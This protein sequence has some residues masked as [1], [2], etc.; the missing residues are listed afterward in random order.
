MSWLNQPLGWMLVHRF[1]MPLVWHGEASSPF[2]VTTLFSKKTYI[3]FLFVLFYFFH[4]LL[5]SCF[6]EPNWGKR[7]AFL[8]P[9]VNICF[10]PL[11]SCPKQQLCA[12]CCDPVCRYRF[13][14]SLCCNSHLLYH[15]LQGNREI[16]QLYQW[17]STINGPIMIN[18]KHKNADFP[19]II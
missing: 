12:R 17:V 6:A 11:I 19:F 14:L 4:L 15:W 1:F 2:Q 13:Y 8:R 16:R 18:C 5:K 3:V 7:I 10:F 9:K